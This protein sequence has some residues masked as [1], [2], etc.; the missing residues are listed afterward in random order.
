M[1]FDARGSPYSA[2]GGALGRAG[3]TVALSRPLYRERVCAV[4][5]NGARKLG[6]RLARARPVCEEKCATPHRLRTCRS[7][8]EICNR[9]CHRTVEE[10]AGLSGIKTHIDNQLEQQNRTKEELRGKSGTV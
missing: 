7:P 2:K 8:A 9:N 4:A 3:K 10:R 1:F 6:R 5:R